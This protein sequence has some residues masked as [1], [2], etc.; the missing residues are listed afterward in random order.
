MKHLLRKY[1]L[2]PILVVLAACWKEP[3]FPKEPQIEFNSIDTKYIED[4]GRKALV[5][6][7]VNFKD[8]DGDLG[9]Q[10][11]AKKEDAQPPYDFQ[12][13]RNKFYYNYFADSF[14]EINGNFEPY[15]PSVITYNGRF[16]HLNTDGKTKALEGELRYSFEV[17]PALLP[18]EFKNGD[19]MKFRVQIAD[20]AL[21]LS[22]TVETEPI[23]ITF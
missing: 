19:R 23:K 6:I 22:N 18:S 3:N 11:V 15:R 14:I 10:A 4:G 8:G 5:T 1:G 7:A 12:E 9:L 20:R 13:G 21:N 17:I 16:T 2:L